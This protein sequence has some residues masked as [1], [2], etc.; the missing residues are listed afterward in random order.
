MEG[1]YIDAD[2]NSSWVKNDDKLYLI[3]I[4]SYSYSI[5]VNRTRGGFIPSFVFN[6]SVINSNPIN[7]PK[8]T[9]SAKTIHI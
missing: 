3:F 2:L 8:N 4:Y 9:Y 5:L 6:L 1:G 7:L